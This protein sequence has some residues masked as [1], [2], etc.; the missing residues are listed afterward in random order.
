MPTPRPRFW[1]ASVVLAL[2]VPGSMASAQGGANA[3]AAAPAAQAEP[4][5]DLLGRDTPRG[6][7]L[8]FMSAARDGK[9]DV[10]PLY[11]NTRLRG[12]A[13][14]D[15]ARQL[16]VVL[17][18]RLPVRVN[19][20]SDRREGS[21]ANPLRPDQ[22]VVGTVSTATGQLDLVVERVTVEGQSVWLFARAT[23]ERIPDVH[24]EIDLVPIDRYLPGFLAVRIV[25]IRLFEWLLLIVVLP[26]GYRLLGLLGWAVSKSVTPYLQRRFHV[27]DGPITHHFPGALRLIV[28]GIVI[29]TASSSFELPLLER[30]FWAVTAFFLAIC[31]L[32][33]SATLLNAFGERY[34]YRHLNAS[35]L[36]ESVALLRLGRRVAD[37]LVY[38]AAF[39]LVLWR[40][41]RDVTAV[42]AGLGIGGIAVALAAQKTLEN[43]IGGVSLVFDKAVRVGDF[44]RLGTTEGTVDEVGL[45]STRIR[46]LER[47]IVT[48][49]N[50]VIAS[51]SI[52]TVS[53][54]DKFWFHHFVGLQ[55]DTTPEQ[56][57]AVTDNMRDLLA[58]QPGVELESV[59][60][61][62]LRLGAFS[63]DIELYAYVFAHDWSAF[64]EIQE[65]LLLRVMEIIERAGTAIAFPSQT[66]HM[67]EGERVSELEEGAKSKADPPGPV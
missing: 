38:A 4:Q 16:Y 29:R 7:V 26:I 12:Q 5:K 66:L 18:S 9:N 56:M 47:T 27:W 60:V 67:A 48:V 14:V 1:F 35:R 32:V 23:L 54:R 62:F 21:L 45:R 10:A 65:K 15:L 58:R 25:G 59:R 34:I 31:G 22:D 49:P 42:L 11:L 44:L 52:E 50:G 33:W 46:T 24:D 30:Q 40:F 39:L 3:P 51:A 8:G 53:D 63:L 55:Y 13:A 57:R 2:A 37:V 28:L 19:E 17:D 36:G 41:D 64:L 6:T 61:R 43:F 20:L